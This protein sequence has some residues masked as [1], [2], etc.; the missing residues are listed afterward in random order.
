MS[1]RNL[2][3]FCI[4]LFS[5]AHASAQ[6]VRQLYCVWE[7]QRSSTNP[8]W[9]SVF[10]GKDNPGKVLIKG[11][12]VSYGSNKIFVSLPDRPAINRNGAKIFQYFGE[13][14]SLLQ[15]SYAPKDQILISL[16]LLNETGNQVAVNLAGSCVPL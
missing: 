14:K 6:P 5:V 3:L 16:T 9:E 2:T 10:L 8:N 15:I 4:A 1:F 11:E 12:T 7:A 13:Q